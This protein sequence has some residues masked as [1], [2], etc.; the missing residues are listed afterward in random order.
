LRS[1]E[2]FRSL[3]LV[4]LLVSSL[5]ETPCTLRLAVR[6]SVKQQEGW[7]AGERWVERYHSNRILQLT[8]SPHLYSSTASCFCSTSNMIPPASLDLTH[9]M[10]CR[11]PASQLS[12]FVPL[13]K[14][15]PKIS[16]RAAVLNNRQHTALTKWPNKTS[17]Q[18]KNSAETDV[19]KRKLLPRIQ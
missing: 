9:G 14:Q 18:Q 7:D 5:Y 2:R 16:G 12:P 10:Y 19:V 6:K 13:S 11:Q 1:Q 15:F 8:R 3:D 17:L 4:I